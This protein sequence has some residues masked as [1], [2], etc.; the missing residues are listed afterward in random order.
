MNR[1]LSRGQKAG[2]ALEKIRNLLMTE[3]ISYNEAKSFSKEPLQ[4]INEELIIMRESI[5]DTH[6]GKVTFTGYMR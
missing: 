2:L 6:K 4:T 3:R 5:N 1:K